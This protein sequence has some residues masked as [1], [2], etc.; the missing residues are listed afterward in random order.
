MAEKRQFPGIGFLGFL[1][2]IFITLKLVGLISWRWVLVL[3]PAIIELGLIV[4]LTI[5][6]IVKEYG[7]SKGDKKNG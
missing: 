5:L 6:L 7:K 4:F 3:L 2:L 1:Q